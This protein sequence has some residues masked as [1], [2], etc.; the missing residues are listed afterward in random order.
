MAEQ[1]SSRALSGVRILDLT[2][3]E[4]GPVCTPPLGWFGGDPFTV[5]SPVGGDPGRRIRSPLQTSEPDPKGF[6]AWYSLVHDSNKHSV[7]LNLKDP[8]GREIVLSLV[9]Q[10]DVVVENMGPRT[11]ERRRVDQD[12]LRSVNEVLS[13]RLHYDEERFARL[14][15]EGVVEPHAR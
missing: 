1:L 13:A 4:S 10:A 7:T 12:V 14:W 9:T 11:L 5:E 6:D 15:S 2:Q 8:R 3:H